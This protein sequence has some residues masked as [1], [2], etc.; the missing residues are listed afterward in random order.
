MDRVRGNDAGDRGAERGSSDHHGTLVDG[1]LRKRLATIQQFVVVVPESILWREFGTPNPDVPDLVG[2]ALAPGVRSVEW[3]DGMSPL[4]DDYVRDHASRWGFD[5]VPGSVA[6]ERQEYHNRPQYL[7]RAR[8]I[9]RRGAEGQNP[10]VE[11]GDRMEKRLTTVFHRVD[12]ALMKADAV[13]NE[14]TAIKGV[15]EQG[16]REHSALVERVDELE[17]S[18]RLQTFVILA[19]IVLGALGLWLL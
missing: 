13:D 2:N 15:V 18:L 9:D 8:V 10:A 6:L 16:V 7:A 5:V 1:N 11:L 17:L 12:T 14:Q 19:V 3:L 4:I